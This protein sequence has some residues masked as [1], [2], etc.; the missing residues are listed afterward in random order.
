M[1][2]I[3]QKAQEWLAFHVKLKNG[4]FVN[5][6]LSLGKEIK[7]CEKLVSFC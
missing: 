4:S 7:G 5:F 3:F 2:S 6:K 1:S